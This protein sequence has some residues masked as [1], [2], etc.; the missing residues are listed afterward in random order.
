[1]MSSSTDKLKCIC[2]NG[3]YLDGVL[4]V[5]DG[6]RLPCGDYEDPDV[7]SEYFEGYIASVDVTN[8]PLFKF[9]GTVINTEIN[10]PGSWNEN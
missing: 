5:V 8:I 6:G 2:P 1:M 4:G 3:M 10:F 9:L 7:Q